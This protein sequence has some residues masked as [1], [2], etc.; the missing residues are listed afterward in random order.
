MT[1]KPPVGLGLIGCGAF[2]RFCLSAY[3]HT[4]AV[5]VVAVADARPD[6]ARAAAT[7]AGARACT[8]SDELLADP[9]VELVHLVTPPADHHALAL[10]ACRAGKHVLCEKPL[11]IDLKQADEMLAAARA[12]GRLCGVNFVLRYNPVTDA[13]KAVIDSGALG[14]VLAARLTNCAEDSR[15]PPDHWFWD[16]AVSGGIFVEHGVHFFD[17]FAHWLGP[18]EVVWAH[19]ATRDRTDL[20]DRAVC[21]LRHAGGAVATHYHG[22]DQITPMDRTDHRLVCELG[23]IVVDGWVPLSVTVDAATDAAG[24]EALSAALPS[25]EV[26]SVTALDPPPDGFFSRGRPRNADRRLRLRYAPQPDKAA[27]YAQGLRDAVA[28]LA[29]AARDPAHRRRI[30]ERNGYDALAAAVA[31]ARLARN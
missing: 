10:A 13:V 27:A 20:Q 22:F 12:A 21:T 6:A 19:T 26:E 28:D 16:R 25:A 2:G 29:A 3:A 14:R 1:T 5:R 11:A 17:L 24:H 8:S 9:R 4:H 7:D 23:D 18:G 30:T 31:A 15:L